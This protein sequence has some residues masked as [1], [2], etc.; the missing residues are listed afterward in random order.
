MS[1]LRNFYLFQF[2]H[3]LKLEIWMIRDGWFLTSFD[4]IFVNHNK[5]SPGFFGSGTNETEAI[6]DLMDMISG[7]TIVFGDKNLEVPNWLN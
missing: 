6:R 1:P 5:N 4:N 3:E 7:K 2:E